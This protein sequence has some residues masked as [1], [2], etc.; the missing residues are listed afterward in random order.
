MLIFHWFYKVFCVPSGSLDPE[1][2]WRN[3]SFRILRPSRPCGNA[4]TL[5]FYWFYNVFCVPSGSLDSKG[6][7][8]NVYAS[9][10]MWITFSDS[11]PQR[12]KIPLVLQGIVWCMVG[13]AQLLQKWGFHWFYKAFDWYPDPKSVHFGF[14][15]CDFEF[16]A[17][18]K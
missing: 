14:R 5:I 15:I 1:G 2:S 8:R 10:F 18:S 4:E 17:K 6:T 7:W 3:A 13:G 9:P 12:G 11:G 16:D